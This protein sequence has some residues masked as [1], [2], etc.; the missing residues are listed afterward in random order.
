MKNEDT[1]C[2]SWIIEKTII[3]IQPNIY[4]HFNSTHVIVSLHV[5]FP[6]R[7]S[8]APPPGKPN[9]WRPCCHARVPGDISTPQTLA[10]QGLLA[11]QLR[12]SKG[13]QSSCSD[14]AHDLKLMAGNAGI[15]FLYPG[16]ENQL[17]S[18]PK[19]TWLDL[20]TTTVADT[21]C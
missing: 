1:P 7:L 11:Q 14:V 16:D 17:F 4:S 20:P 2:I 15:D 12:P 18:M 3:S 9:R 6:N 5:L 13:V 21:F 10:P 19:K 8:G